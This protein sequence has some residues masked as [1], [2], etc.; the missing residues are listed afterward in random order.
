MPT[1]PKLSITISE[2]D[3]SAFP[4]ESSAELFP[5]PIPILF[6]SASIDRSK[7]VVCEFALFFLFIRIPFTK[8]ELETS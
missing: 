4:F 2:L 8:S 3:K 5:N 1:R 6:S 7:K